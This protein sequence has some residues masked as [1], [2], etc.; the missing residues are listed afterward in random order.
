MEDEATPQPADL[1]FD[2]DRSGLHGDVVD[3]MLHQPEVTRCFDDWAGRVRA[4]DDG[5]TLRLGAFALMHG[6][7]SGEALSEADPHT[8]FAAA[9]ADRAHVLREF[10]V[11]TLAEDRRL[12]RVPDAPP[13]PGESDPSLPHTSASSVPSSMPRAAINDRRREPGAQRH[14]RP[15]EG[16][17][18]GTSRPTETHKGLGESAEPL[19][20]VGCG[21]WI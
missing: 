14:G 10:R 1:F 2:T 21:G 5:F 15:R 13:P 7:D 12:G 20:F 17:S 3:W 9:N 18:F 16:T 4:L 11:S 19:V 8:L 6:F